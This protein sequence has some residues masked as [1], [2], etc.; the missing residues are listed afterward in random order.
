LRRGFWD[1]T[2][3]RVNQQNNMTATATN[4]TTDPLFNR[5]LSELPSTTTVNVRFTAPRKFAFDNPPTVEAYTL[6]IPTAE[7]F[8]AG[9][10]LSRRT[11]GVKF[12]KVI[13]WLR[14]NGHERQGL[15]LCV[16]I[17]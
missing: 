10:W 5:K 17:A 9:D 11:A 8:E 7:I 6:E 16:S 1:D 15:E 2:S 4:I 13:A 12:S 14:S 3:F